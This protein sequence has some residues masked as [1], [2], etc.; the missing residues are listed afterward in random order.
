MALFRLPNGLLYDAAVGLGA[1]RLGDSGEPLPLIVEMPGE[2]MSDGGPDRW[3]PAVKALRDLGA[4]RI[5]LVPAS[6]APGLPDGA[7]DGRNDLFV[8]RPSALA[9]AEHG[10]HR[11][12]WTSIPVEGDRAPTV[13]AAAARAAGAAVPEAGE[14][15]FLLRF[16]DDARP[17]PTAGYDSLVNGRL[18]PQMVAGRTVLVG[19]ASGPGLNTPVTPGAETMSALAFHASAFATLLAGPPLEFG[20]LGTVVLVALACALGALVY[21]RIG[22]RLALWTA[23][24]VVLLLLALGYAV[25]RWGGAVLPLTELLLSQLLLLP[26]V[27]RQREMEQDRSLR[28]ILRGVSTQVRERLHRGTAEVEADRVPLSMALAARLLN[29]PKSL[30]LEPDGHALRE[31]AAHGCALADL[32]ADARDPLRPPY[33]QA[34]A[35][36]PVRPAKGLLP[37]GPGEA[38]FVAPLPPDG[39]PLAYWV[40]VAPEQPGQDRPAVPGFAAIAEQLGD[41]LVAERSVAERP[42]TDAVGKSVDRQIRRIVGQLEHRLDLLEAVLAETSSAIA[43]FD[44]FARPQLVNDRMGEVLRDAGLAPDLVTPLDLLVRGAG[45]DPAEA[46]GLLRRIM[47]DGGGVSLPARLGGNGTRYLLK[48]SAP[49]RPALAGENGRWVGGALLCELVDVTDV[50]RLAGFQATLA[51]HLDLQLRNEMEAILLA[52]DL[53]GDARLGEAGRARALDR[54]RGAVERTRERL[55]R[56]GAFFDAEPE[57]AAQGLYPIDPREPLTAALEHAAEEASRRR[58][59][60]ERRWP[61]LVTLV[62][63]GA[64]ETRELMLAILL[65]LVRDAREGAAVLVELAEGPQDVVVRCTSDG[66]GMPQERLRD[67][68]LGARDPDS[69]E[70]RAIQAGARRLAAWGGRLDAMSGVGTGFDFRLCLRKLL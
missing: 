64:R 56:V 59:R 65:L 69:A 54:L 52:A 33:A 66:V 8:A 11:R 1:A 14:R 26:L 44:P 22:P 67:V 68:V 15:G 55:A 49:S 42:D 40:F 53:L 41:L 48:L 4:A 32:P 43:V 62:V 46:G 60:L 35:A 63:A 37:A 17:L 57:G 70:L 2:G 16:A 3:T 47:S 30:L 61:E 36:G 23:L 13:E 25:L 27:Q 50:S 45:V 38:A 29:L 5:L 39:D 51:R 6:G 19:P 34:A 9:P 12:Q 20:L 18:L 24:A 7:Q 31:V 10:I 28:C 58:V 21:G